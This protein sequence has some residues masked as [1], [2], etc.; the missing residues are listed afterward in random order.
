MNV[1]YTI[2]GARR[3]ILVKGRGRL[4]Y[5]AARAAFA[6]L[7]GDG[8]FDAR[9]DRIWDLTEVAG[10]EGPEEARRL[11]DFIRQLQHLMGG[12]RTAVVAWPGVCEALSR[13]LT[14]DHAGPL[15]C[16]TAADHAEAWFEGRDTG[17]ETL[18]GTFEEAGIRVLG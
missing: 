12:C 15:R 1:T 3:R 4:S 5:A 10:G 14:P 16:F 2:D 9:Y 6:D 17:S 18:F 8:S 7:L 11:A 13:C